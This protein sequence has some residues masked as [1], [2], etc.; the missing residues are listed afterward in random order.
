MNPELTSIPVEVRRIKDPAPANTQPA[1]PGRGLEITWSGGEKT[2]IDSE[3]LRRNCPCATCM[4]KRGEASHAKPLAGKSSALRVLSA[5]LEQET[6]LREVW[7]VGNY[8]LGISW[9]DGHETGIYSYAHLR[10]LTAK[11]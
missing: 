10:K 5:T 9:G 6:N 8:A 11:E 2:I 4:E 3:T 7:P 1:P